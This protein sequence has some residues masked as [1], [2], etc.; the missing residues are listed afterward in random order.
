VFLYIGLAGSQFT[1]TNKNLL[2]LVFNNKDA[3]DH[4]EVKKQNKKSSC[5]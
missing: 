1:L 5:C 2:K 4:G 3:N